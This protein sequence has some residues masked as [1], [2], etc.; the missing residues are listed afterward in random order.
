MT[1]TRD[2][3]DLLER[4]ERV[5][6]ARDVL[7]ATD[8]SPGGLPLEGSHLG[9]AIAHARREAGLGV[10]ELARRLDCSSETLKRLEDSPFEAHSLEMLRRVAEALGARIHLEFL[11]GR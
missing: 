10:D 6:E 11:P 9:R 4:R 1:D 7:R 5:A 3:I 8:A 2:W